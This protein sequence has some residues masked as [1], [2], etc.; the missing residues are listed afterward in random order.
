MI[1]LLLLVL[2][3]SPLHA[4]AQTPAPTTCRE[5]RECRQMGLD[6]ADR[7]EYERFHDLAWRAMQTGPAKDPALMLLLA[8]AQVLSGRPHDALVML[9]R[10]AESGVATDAATNAEFSRTREL[11]GWP[12]VAA[13]IAAAETPPPSPAPAAA[14]TASTLRA[15]AASRQPPA[16]RPE[17]PAPSATI[18]AAAPRAPSAA[19]VAP[20]AAAAAPAP[21]AAPAAAAARSS[22]VVKTPTPFP[23]KAAPATDAARFSAE[24]FSAGG[25]A[26]DAVSQRFVIGDALGRK[27]MVVGLGASHPIDMVRS[28]SA[29]FQDVVSLEIDGRRG[30]LWV[31][32]GSGTGGDSAL[33]RLQL[34]SGRPLKTYHAVAS[35]GPTQLTD[36]TIE[37]SGGVVALDATPARLLRLTPDA[38]DIN[39]AMPLSLP[40]ATSVAAATEE[41][42]VYVAHGEG[43]A[44]VDLRSHS[45]AALTTPR[46]FD[47]SRFER[48]RV[49]RSALIGLQTTPEGGHQIVRLNLNAAG[50]AVTDATVIDPNVP[51]VEG[52]LFL[53]ISGDELY[54]LS[55]TSGDAAAAPT[56]GS[57]P[58]AP[59]VVRRVTLR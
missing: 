42:I 50:R 47:L 39:V 37:P 2:I 40:A 52:R 14:A 33:H 32:S 56:S 38:A 25:L 54:Y 57:T 19:P 18:A 9:K 48:I 21:G 11:P 23:I 34:V 30:D 13:L 55:T 31:A 49:Y 27:L 4:A 43:I 5:W 1:V 36:L 12:E 51:A 53:T 7:G 46:G 29:G 17:K 44:R 24:R 10:L 15:T 3:G 58:L 26:Y 59:F 45:T 22:A 35:A 41:G 8:R 28:D 6:A 20:S 16:A